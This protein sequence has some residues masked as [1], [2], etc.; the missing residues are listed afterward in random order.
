KPTVLTFSQVLL[1]QEFFAEYYH[2][3]FDFFH[4]KTIPLYALYDTLSGDVCVVREIIFRAEN[5][6]F[7]PKRAGRLTAAFLCR[8]ALRA[9]NLP[10]LFPGGTSRITFVA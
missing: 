9:R 1:R 2:R 8:Y 3:F 4:G 10:F 6:F 7:T 5:A